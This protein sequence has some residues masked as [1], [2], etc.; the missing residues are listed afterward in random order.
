MASSDFKIFVG[1]LT[2]TTVEADLEQYF[3]AF[4]PVNQVAIIRNKQTGLS[5][6]YAFIHTSDK[7]TYHR[8]LNQK[9][10][11]QGR[12]IDCKDGFS[13]EENPQL[14]E[15]MNSKKFFVGGLSVA[16]ADK[17]LHEYFSRFGSV[18]KAYV[19]VDP[20][21]NRSKR[22]G[23]VIMD[24]EQGVDT[25]MNGGKHTINGS[26]VNCKRF[27]R[28][29]SEKTEQEPAD[30]EGAETPEQ[31]KATD[32]MEAESNSLVFNRLSQIWSFSGHSSQI[33]FQFVCSKGKSPQMIE[34]YQIDSYRGVK[35]PSSTKA[36]S[37]TQE[38]KFRLSMNPAL[39]ER[40]ESWAQR[41]NENTAADNFESII[42][43]GWPPGLVENT[44]S[45]N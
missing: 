15:K 17:N 4:G 30:E 5:K 32:I 20:N 36:I 37:A 31:G 28:S 40:I 12:M 43:T 41:C 10:Y 24:S 9:H 25:V 38:V 14:F 34:H 35:T 3:A 8:I 7:R 23:F 33:L 29:I 19:I 16:T 27:D 44:T 2:V 1:G 42:E 22:F 13:R 45:I 21:T 18:F 6:C 11:I 26:I 39:Y